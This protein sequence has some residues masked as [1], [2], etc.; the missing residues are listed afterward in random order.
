MT[1]GKVTILII[2]FLWVGYAIILFRRFK[3]SD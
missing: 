1:L 2:L 3:G